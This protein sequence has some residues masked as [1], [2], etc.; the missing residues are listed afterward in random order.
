MPGSE[1][2]GVLSPS[3]HAACRQPILECPLSRIPPGTSSRPC[4]AQR[5]SLE[6]KGAGD[7]NIHLEANPS[8]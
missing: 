5:R 3:A 6:A 1:L 2:G 4:L 8:W 7:G